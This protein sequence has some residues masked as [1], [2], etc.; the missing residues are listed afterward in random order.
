MYKGNIVIIR[1]EELKVRSFNRTNWSLAGSFMRLKE[2]FP[3]VCLCLMKDPQNTLLACSLITTE[4][5]DYLKTSVS[6]SR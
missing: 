6:F 4:V 1:R 5:L 2:A 3:G